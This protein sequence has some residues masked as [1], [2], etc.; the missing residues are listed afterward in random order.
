MQTNHEELAQAHTTRRIVPRSQESLACPKLR[1]IQPDSNLLKSARLS[2]VRADA[3]ALPAASL[4]DLSD[5]DFSRRE[6]VAPY[7]AAL[8]QF[9]EKRF[10]ESNDLFMQFAPVLNLVG[11]TAT[12]RE[13][14][15]HMSIES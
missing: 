14:I 13:L 2:V 11:G 3:P 12:Q 6:F 4:V 8:K 1:S 7:S 9:T 10:G 15:N 5:A